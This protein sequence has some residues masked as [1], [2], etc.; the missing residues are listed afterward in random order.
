M[1]LQA[2]ICLLNGSNIQKHKLHVGLMGMFTAFQQG[3]WNTLKVRPSK[4]VSNQ[5]QKYT[6]SQ[7]CCTWY[8]I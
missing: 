7:G 8:E 3:L 6:G 5:A 2:R 1:I 4:K